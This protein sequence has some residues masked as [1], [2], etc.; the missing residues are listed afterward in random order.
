MLQ[1]SL[2]GPQRFF[3]DEDLLLAWGAVHKR[4]QKGQTVIFEGDEARFFYQIVSGSIKMVNQ[5]KDGKEFVHGYFGP[6]ESFAEP[7]LFLGSRYPASAVANEDTV[8]IR[9]NRERFFQILFKSVMNREMANANPEYRIL[10]L[11]KH[12]KDTCGENKPEI[13]AKYG[14]KVNFTRQEIAD[15]TGLRV[16]TVIR[17]MKTLEEKGEL[18]IEKGKVYL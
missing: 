11:I 17:S 3:I 15:M 6:G 4:I 16:E 14:F 10:S 5:N 9:L 12:F 18:K 7:P 1:D 2:T 13:L 8:V